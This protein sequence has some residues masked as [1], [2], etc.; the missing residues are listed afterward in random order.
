MSNPR[1]RICNVLA[2]SIILYFVNNTLKFP[3]CPEVLLSGHG[4]DKV[5]TSTK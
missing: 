1:V 3:A 2:C 4:L 5:Q